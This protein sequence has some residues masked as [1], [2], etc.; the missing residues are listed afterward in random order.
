MRIHCLQHVRYEG[1]ALIES[2]ATEHG[3]EI[4]TSPLYEEPILPRPETI[5]FLVVVGGAMGAYDEDAY[6]WIAEEKTFIERFIAGGSP[7]LGI[8]L[9]AQLIADVLGARVY[10]GP[11]KE[12]GWFPIQLTSKGRETMLLG[13]L[14]E[15]PTVFHW[16]SDT[17]NLP[18]NTIHLARSDAYDNQ[19]F[20]YDDRVL[21]LQFHLELDGGMIRQIIDHS[22][23][24]DETAEFVQSPEEMVAP[25]QPFAPSHEILYTLLNRL[26]T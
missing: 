7:V 19:A 18:E 4:D 11:R 6:P 14:P 25:H 21:G 23:E 12:M 22:N 5:D 8:C 20:L 1:P 16:H 24:H 13:D 26:T 17:F 3:H 15:N 9:G 2:W 10:P